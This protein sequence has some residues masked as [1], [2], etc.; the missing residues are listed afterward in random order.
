[1]EK[2]Y[3]TKELLERRVPDY[4]ERFWYLSGPPPMV[5]AYDVLLKKNGVKGSMITKD[6]FPGLA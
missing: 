4:K 1:M 5:N 6:F 3:I 2:G